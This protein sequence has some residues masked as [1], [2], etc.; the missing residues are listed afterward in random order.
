MLRLELLQDYMDSIPTCEGEQH[1]EVQK[2]V[3]RRRQMAAP[4]QLPTRNGGTRVIVA[5]LIYRPSVLG[6]L[7]CRY[8]Q[9]LYRLCFLLIYMDI[10]DKV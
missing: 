1:T 2:R 6:S 4:V 8:S 10:H 9:T 7:S 3:G 5:P